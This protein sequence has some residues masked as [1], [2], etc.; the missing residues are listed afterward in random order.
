MKLTREQLKGVR[1]WLKIGIPDCN[2][3]CPFDSWTQDHYC[4]EVCPAV[5][6]SLPKKRKAHEKQILARA[7]ALYGH[8]EGVDSIESLACPCHCYPRRYVVRV[9]RLL[10]ARHGET[11][12]KKLKKEVKKHGLN[13]FG[14]NRK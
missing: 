2:R 9:A 10:L 7:Y 3:I 13:V 12:V 5:F 4:R 6:P 1:E 14:G 11:G 8:S